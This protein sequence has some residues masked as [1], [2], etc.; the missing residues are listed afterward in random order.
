M[1]TV[2]ICLIGV[3]LAMDACAV[4]LAKGMCLRKH[5]MRYALLLGMVFGLFQ[6]LMPL[7]GWWA[8]TYFESYITAIDHWIAFFLLGFIGY[9]M[10][11][12]GLAHDPHQEAQRDSLPIKE[13][14]VLGIATSIDALAIGVSFAFLQVDIL[15]AICLIAAITFAI[16]FLAVLL[17][18]SL[19]AHLGI[20]AELIGGVLLI[21][22]GV[23]IL[24]EHLCA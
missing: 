6:G 5:L 24:L 12:E 21:L 11:R 19:G 23:K 3:G 10:C 13:I 14:M 15:L 8:G 1:N 16:S 4:S 18:K 17:G 2:S 9:R 20:Y 7:L 22:I